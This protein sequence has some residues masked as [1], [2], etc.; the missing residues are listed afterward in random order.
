MTIISEII[1]C[2]LLQTII[3][4]LK[5]KSLLNKNRDHIGSKYKIN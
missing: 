4:H 1:F 3:L 2:F 5:Y